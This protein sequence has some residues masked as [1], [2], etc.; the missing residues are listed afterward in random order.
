M[1]IKYIENEKDKIFYLEYLK[2]GE[3]NVNV[4]LHYLNYYVNLIKLIY[5]LRGLFFKKK[6]QILYIFI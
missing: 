3:L 5:T 4:K 6:N 2:N 1:F